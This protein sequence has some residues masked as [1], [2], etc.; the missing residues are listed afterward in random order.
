GGTAMW[1]EGMGGRRDGRVVEPARIDEAEAG[2]G[3]DVLCVEADYLRSAKARE[4]VLRHL[5]RGR[6]VLLLVDRGSPLVKGFLRD[7]GL[8]LQGGESPRG[9]S[10]GYVFA[11]HPIFRPFASPDFGNLMEVRVYRHRRLRAARAMPLVFS[12]E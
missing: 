8:E 4:L 5:G 7:L 1:R 9:S 11:D 10:F 6:G 12:P 3:P 2:A